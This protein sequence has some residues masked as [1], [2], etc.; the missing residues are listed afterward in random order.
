MGFQR[1]RAKWMHGGDRNTKY[2][3]LKAVNRK[4]KNRII[5]LCNESGQWMEDE[6]Q[7]KTHV[8]SYFKDFFSDGSNNGDYPEMKYHFSPLDTSTRVAL[9]SSITEAEIDAAIFSM[10][11]W[12]A[13]GPDGFQA[14]FYQN[15]W[16]LVRDACYASSKG[17]W[18]NSELVE[19]INA[20]DICLIPKVSKPEFII[21]FRPISLCNVNYKVLTKVIVNRLKPLMPNIISPYQTRFI[22][23]RSIH[24]NII[25]A[26]EILHSM[27]K[28]RSK[29]G[30]FVI[31]VDLAK[32]YAKIR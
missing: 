29:N 8:T 7:I 12:K 20:T 14:G 13:P 5:M 30:F 1:S 17:V 24:E 19:N 4:K 32:A 26:Q 2:Y 23:T 6:D 11:P 15:N 22:P 3:H 10:Q 27:R 31:K 28:M 25:V 16:P 21:K 9:D 18:S